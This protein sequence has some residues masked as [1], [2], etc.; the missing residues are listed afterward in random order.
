VFE[1]N[2]AYRNVHCALCNNADLSK[3]IC[4]NLGPFG[5]FNWQQVTLQAEQNNFLCIIGHY[6]RLWIEI[7]VTR[8]VIVCSGS[9]LKIEK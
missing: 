8:K 3:L 4:L 9:F 5:R 1:P 6:V 2:T 7:R